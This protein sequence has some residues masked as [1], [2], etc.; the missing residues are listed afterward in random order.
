ME[1]VVNLNQTV[2]R[3][4]A[5]RAEIKQSR[6]TIK[7]HETDLRNAITSFPGNNGSQPFEIRHHLQ[8]DERLSGELSTLINQGNDQ[9][10]LMSAAALEMNQ[11]GIE[12]RNAQAE[13]K[14]LREKRSS[15]RKMGFILL[16]LVIGF[17]M[18]KNA[19][20][21]EEIKKLEQ[22]EADLERRHREANSRLDLARNAALEQMASIEAIS[23]NHLNRQ[24][25]EDAEAWQE[26]W[27]SLPPFLTGDWSEERWSSHDFRQSHRLP[28]FS[29]GTAYE[30]PQEGAAEFPLPVLAPF[31][32]HHHCY[33]LEGDGD[34][35]LSLMQA[36]IVQL[37]T[38]M[39]Y[40]ATITLLDPSGAGRAFPMQRQLPH[41]RAVGA[42]A[43]RDLESILEEI[44][45]LI[46]TYLDEETQSFDQLPE[47]IQANE[48][49]EFIFAANFPENYDRRTIEAMQSIARNG[50]VAGKYLFLQQSDKKEL[51]SDLSWNDF[52]NL[53]SLPVGSLDPPA[54]GFAPRV[55]SSPEG[56]AQ[57]M[58]LKLL[59][60][61]KPPETKI[62]WE[63]LC[64]SD[65]G[66]WWSES[67]ESMVSAPV[68]SSGRERKLT[69]WFGANR[70]G[71]PCAHG[72]LGAMTGSGKSNLYHV[73]IC[74]LATRY[75]PEE[76][77]LYL[78]DGK[79]GVEFQAYRNLPH[80]RVVALHSSPDLSRS[81]LDELLT[82][83]KLRNEIFKSRNV[84]DLKEYRSLDGGDAVMPRIVLMIDEYQELFENDRHGEASAA[85]L[86]L[87]QQGRSAGIHMLLGSQ[88][89]GAVGMLNQAAIFGN[90]HLRI[91]MKM[92]QSDVQG[93]TEF[94]R[95]GRRLIEQCDLP[96]KIVI[97]DQ[98]GEDRSNEFGKVALLESESRAET[99]AA[100]VEKA[101][102]EWPR[103]Q[104]FATVVFDG[105]EQPNLIENPQ[106]VDLLRRPSRPTPEEWRLVA[107]SSMKDQGFAVPDWFHGE[108][109]VALW[110]G[111]EPSVYGQAIVTLRRRP[112]EN[113]LLVGDNQSA[114]VGM[115]AGIL[116][117]MAINET[118]KDIKIRV[119]DRSVPGTPWNDTLG[120]V[121]DDLLKPL[122]Y[123]AELATDSK[124][125][126]TWLDE[127]VAE[128]DRRLEADEN[129]LISMPTWIL[130][131]SGADRVAQLLKT[132]SK[133]GTAVDSDDGGKLARIYQEGSAL[134]IHLIISFPGAGPLTQCLGRDQLDRFKHR[135]ATQMSESDS[136]LLLGKDGAS[137]L[138]KDG[139]S[140]VMAAFQDAVVSRTKVF[141]PYVSSPQISWGEQIVFFRDQLE[142]W[143]KD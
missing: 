125:A 131:I 85:L 65:P 103:D 16:I 100:L 83:M 31:L 79:V 130:M 82:E 5:R 40:G 69:M 22:A 30:S 101:K 140:P 60:D 97:N 135:V 63:D 64:D 87:A 72:V 28:F 95:N 4:L 26:T 41:V 86:Q 120:Q 7:S 6:G 42:D 71:R 143:K 62:S 27:K 11:L 25:T 96:G 12:F 20:S 59:A 102:T 136:F 105:Q 132:Q 81:V 124:K 77:N 13:T 9:I 66:D 114:A 88:R 29:V 36:L 51:P 57:S 47:Q 76:L 99:I 123:D 139:P 90:V 75:S 113:V 45:R 98:S 21:L 127:C 128:I 78:I 112:S 110:L 32:G 89:F 122:S 118:P 126:V 3:A 91:A 49:Y 109:P 70:E 84:S 142:R 137:K 38:T 50:P 35:T 24:L 55:L 104:Q 1:H 111:Q 2:S 121:V 19:P 80:A 93:L 129:D 117:A 108:R 106:V 134:G 115:L 58:V 33:R 141:K 46:H 138:Q 107:G 10:K 73:L 52:A 15:M 74:G 133:F 18:L 119:L 56:G 54:R 17:F 34:T 8:Q 68:G 48:R 94:G 67:A 92:S 44:T 53:Y 61:A 23:A 39:P 37:A 116:C 43:F 14:A